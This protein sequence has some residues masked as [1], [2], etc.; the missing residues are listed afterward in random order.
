MAEKV[1]SYKVEQLRHTPQRRR[2]LFLGMDVIGSFMARDVSL[3]SESTESVTFVEAV[4]K[5]STGSRDRYPGCQRFS[6][7][8]A[9]KRR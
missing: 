7:R 9:V 5:F 6:K 1:A 8:R 4:G 3:R 2:R